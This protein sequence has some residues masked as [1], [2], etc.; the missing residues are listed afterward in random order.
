MLDKMYV[1]DYGLTRYEL[2]DAAVIKKYLRMCEDRVSEID[3][4]LGS[5]AEVG[6]LDE[7]VFRFCWLLKRSGIIEK[8]WLSRICVKY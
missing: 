8:S 3:W 6:M 4:N 5:T 7:A 1:E 2:G